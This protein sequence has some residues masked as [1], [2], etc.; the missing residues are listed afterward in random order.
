M[1]KRLEE[2]T[3]D[4]V[5]AFGAIFVGERGKLVMHRGRF[6]TVPIAISQE[7]REEGDAFSRSQPRLTP[8]EA[9]IPIAFLS[10]RLTTELSRV[11]VSFFP[12]SLPRMRAKDVE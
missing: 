3:S 12:K 7:P 9:D 1:L 2:V 6:N 11:R 8:V 10:W 4:D 5:S